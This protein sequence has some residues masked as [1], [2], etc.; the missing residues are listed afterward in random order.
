MKKKKLK[1]KKKIEEVLW[2]YLSVH[3]RYSGYIDAFLYLCNYVAILFCY[4]IS[5]NYWAKTGTGE[6]S[7][8]RGRLTQHIM[9]EF[10]KQL[11]YL[12]TALDFL[13]AK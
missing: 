8:S 9:R 3:A 13:D 11:T 2:F 6:C 1:L 7:A 4:F 12:I 10:L 5:E